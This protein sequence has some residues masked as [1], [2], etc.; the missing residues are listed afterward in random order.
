M[1]DIIVINEVELNPPGNDNYLSIKEWIELYNPNL[2]SID[3]G[4]WTLETTHGK[5][6]TVTIPYGT[7]IGAYS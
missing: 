6:V 1:I 5:T 2:N 3:I 7:T 4:G